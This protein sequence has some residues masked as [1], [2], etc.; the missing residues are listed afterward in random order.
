VELRHLRSL[1]MLARE[2][3]FTRAA[4]RLRIAQ[5]ALSQ[6]IRGLERE[7]GV[8][9]VARTNRTSGLTD[10]GARLV[11]RAEQILLAVQDATKEMA[12]CAGEEGGTVRIGCALQTLVEGRLPGLLASFHRRHPRIRLV[13]REVHTRQVFQLLQRAE[14]DLGLLHLGRV[15]TTVVGLRTAAQ[16]IALAR[17]YS[18]PLVLI[19][20]PG[21]PLAGRT[22]VDLA[23]LRDET[24]VSFRPGATVREMLLLAARRTGFAPRIGFATAN[25]GSVRAFVS[26]NLGVALVPRCAVEVPSPPLKAIAIASP[27]LERVITLATNTARYEAPAVKEIRRLLS[28]SLRARPAQTR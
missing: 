11:S 21:H 22:Q 18:E 27:R 14:V 1:V 2:R 6:Q 4:R 24:F 15:G 3:N 17:L 10:A 13:L 7:L 26:A 9:L 23:D 28:D 12:A 8:R 20:G 19:V 16:T 5:P 25:M